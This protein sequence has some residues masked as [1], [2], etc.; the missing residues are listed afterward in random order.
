MEG[1]PRTWS[2]SRMKLGVNVAILTYLHL[3]RSPRD[4]LKLVGNNTMCQHVVSPETSV[5]AP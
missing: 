4:G 2:V 1:G 3:V 5:T